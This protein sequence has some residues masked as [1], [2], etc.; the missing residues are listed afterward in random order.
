MLN[1]ITEAAINDD[2]GAKNI[3][4]DHVISLLGEIYIALEVLLKN[5][6]RPMLFSEA[7]SKY[8]PELLLVS[9]LCVF[10]IFSGLYLW[11]HFG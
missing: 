8:L 4:R 7:L 5:L 1:Y 9:Y 3:D 2:G 10:Y 11:S 6:K